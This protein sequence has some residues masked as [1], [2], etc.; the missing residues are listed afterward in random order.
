V[1]T[2]ADAIR[3][4][5]EALGGAADARNVKE[6][7]EARYPGRWVDVT[8]DMA[9]LTYPGNASSTYRHENRFLERVGRGRYR[10]RLLD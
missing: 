3:E 9:D 8:V 4:A 1:T 2:A 5:M 10:L 7:V 6:W